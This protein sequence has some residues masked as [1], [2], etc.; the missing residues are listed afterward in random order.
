MNFEL[1]QQAIQEGNLSGSIEHVEMAL[2]QGISAEEILNQGCITAMNEVG[3]DFESGEIFVP[4]MLIAARAMQC[5]LNVLKPLLTGENVSVLGSVL[6]GTV[7]GD[8]H[9]IGK[10]LVAIM[11]EGAG[12][13]VIDLG[14]DVSPDEFAQAVKEHRPD[15]VG[16]S[17]LLTTTMA[18]IPRTIDKLVE[19]NVRQQVKIVIGGAPVTQA[20]AN[21]S[22]ADGYAENAAAAVR[23]VKSLLNIQ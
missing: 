13:E 23:V 3:K 19:E 18:S 5:A 21:E 16:L 22:G 17:A 11:I 9:D 15:V 4:E 8:L 1:L 7:M 10:N 20:F 2:K 12:F 6:V 14:S